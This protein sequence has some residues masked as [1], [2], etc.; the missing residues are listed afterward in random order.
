VTK[1]ANEGKTTREI[2]KQAHM[3]LLD[4]GKIIRKITK[5]DKVLE[6]DQ[7]KQGELEEKNRLKKLSPYAQAFQ[8]FRDK[9]Q[10]SEV[11]VALDLKSDVVVEYY[12]DYLNLINMKRLVN[13][14][15]EIGDDIAFFLYLYKRIKEEELDALDRIGELLHNIKQLSKV[16]HLLNQSKNQ[17]KGLNIQR[18]NLEIYIN[19]LTTRLG[20]YDG[21]LSSLPL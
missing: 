7:I 2:A 4:I 11:V 9:K 8:M 10:L 12:A 20:N 19:Q 21:T 13:I 18:E 16:D 14:Y 17:L 3:S 1:L 15:E 6:Q 5:D